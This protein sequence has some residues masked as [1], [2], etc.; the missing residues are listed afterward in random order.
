MLALADRSDQE[1]AEDRANILF[2]IVRD[3]AYRLRR[4]TKDELVKGQDNRELLN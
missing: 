4:L 2:G 3:A 1:C